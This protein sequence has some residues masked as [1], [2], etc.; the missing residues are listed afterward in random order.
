MSSFTQRRFTTSARLR[1][2]KA[3]PSSSTRGERPNPSDP[4]AEDKPTRPSEA[5]VLRKKK[6]PAHPAVPQP[7]VQ[8]TS[9]RPARP[10]A[11][12]AE[13]SND[14]NPRKSLV[15]S[16]SRS[17]DAEVQAMLEPRS[18]RK[19]GKSKR[20]DRSASR[21]PPNRSSVRSNNTPSTDDHRGSRG[22]FVG[23]DVYKLREELE[24]MKK[25]CLTM[26]S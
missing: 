16:M 1:E 26:W 21:E 24:A 18:H 23:E 3:G 7:A 9:V 22:P 17:S 14:Q 11:A 13:G 5:H 25:V 12:S 10:L 20:R 4:T 15:R 2:N 8:G 19:H 6:G